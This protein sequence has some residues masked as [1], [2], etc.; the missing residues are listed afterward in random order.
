MEVLTGVAPVAEADKAKFKSEG[1]ARIHHDDD[2][3]WN[4]ED[5]LEGRKKANV[6]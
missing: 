2:R 3:S 1:E 4:E 6:V 5:S